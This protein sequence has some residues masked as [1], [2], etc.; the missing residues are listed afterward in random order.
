MHKFTLVHDTTKHSAVYSPVK[1]RSRRLSRQCVRHTKKM[2][3][4]ITLWLGSE[5]WLGIIRGKVG[6]G[7]C[8]TPQLTG[9]Q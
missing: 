7:K 5:L 2:A 8:P 9:V 4:D 3:N 1:F 6:E